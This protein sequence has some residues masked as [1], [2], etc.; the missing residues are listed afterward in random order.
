MRRNFRQRVVY[1]WE[2][3]S[4]MR[5]HIYTGMMGG[6]YITLV[7][8]LLFVTYGNQI[9]MTPFLWGLMGG[10]SSFVLAAQL[11]SALLTQRLGKRKLVWFASSMACRVIRLLAILASLWLWHTGS[12]LAAAALI[13]GVCLSN[14]FGAVSAPPWMSWLADLIPEEEH[15]GFWGRRSAWVEVSI[16]CAILPASFLVDHVPGAWK[17]PSLM[18]VFMAAT[19]IGV[20]DL[21]IHGT[22]PEPEMAI[23]EQDHF[24]AQILAPVR[25]RGFRPWLLFNLF[26]TFSMTLG[27]SLSMIYFVEDLGLSRNLL[28]GGIVL[29]IFPM[30]GGILTGARSGRMVDRRGAK[31]VLWWGHLFWATLPAFWVF[32]TPRSALVWIG[33]ASLVSGTASR[34]ATIAASKIVTRYPPP[35]HVAMYVAVS[36]C[37]GSLAAGIGAVA[38]GALLRGLDGWCVEVWG[39]ALVPFHVLFIASV[40]LRFASTLLIARIPEA[41]VAPSPA[42]AAEGVGE[43]PVAVSE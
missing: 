37:L 28:G 18:A 25:D 42:P 13:A 32:A 3:P 16:A 8:G 9:G 1:A 2:L 15:G 24:L 7:S 40:V 33:L 6:I 21:V 22:L 35:E 11:L 4:I 19:A 10:I 38:A 31:P 17:M 27:G 26:W 12:H 23:P 30:L 20:V 43:E 41:H 39:L 36:S 34:A 29:I 14:L 5:K